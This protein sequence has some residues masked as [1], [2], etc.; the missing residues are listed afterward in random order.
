MP[1]DITE[2]ATDTT[3]VEGG[4]KQEDSATED[5]GEAG[6]KALAQER[7]ARKAAEKQLAEL[8]RKVQQFEDRDKTD[9]ER[10]QSTATR[11]EQEL[12]QERSARLRLE[13]ATEHGIPK[14]FLDLLTGTDEDTLTSQA[15]RIAALVA[16]KTPDRLPGQGTP[17]TAP[18]PSVASGAAL[19]QQ[20]HKTN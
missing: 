8:T 6:K 5:L 12:A 4:D 14:D 3:E 9:L 17:A 2:D 13:T 20:R 11:L 18:T 10:L 1:N 16:Q 7:S 19:Y 15:Q